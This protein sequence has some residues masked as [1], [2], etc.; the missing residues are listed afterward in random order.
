MFFL[1]LKFFSNFSFSKKKNQENGSDLALFITYDK[2]PTNNNNQSSLLNKNLT[3]QK[4]LSIKDS[5]LLEYDPL[6]INNDG[7]KKFTDQSESIFKDNDNND[8]NG[9]QSSSSSYRFILSY[10]EMTEKFITQLQHIVSGMVFVNILHFLL[11]F[12]Y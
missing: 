11:L 2:F 10:N 1:S 4:S 7:D 8:S 12:C 9:K 3:E 6:M 5:I